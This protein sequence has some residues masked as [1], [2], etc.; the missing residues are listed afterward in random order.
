M[1]AVLGV[2][3]VLLCSACAY[4]PQQIQIAP[5]LGVTAK[6]Y[7]QGMPVTVVARD[8]RSAQV[9]GSRG[10]VYA[11]TSTISISNNLTQ[12]VEQSATARLAAQGFSVNGTEQGTLMTL[13]V[14][15]IAYDV[16][17]NTIPKEIKMEVVMRVELENDGRTLTNRYK[18]EAEHR[19]LASPNAEKNQKM[20]NDLLSQT[21]TRVF[22]DPKVMAFL[23]GQI[24]Q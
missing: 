4:S 11:Q 16:I 6:R 5:D 1:K 2:F 18:T 21:M 12:A 22:E 9:I 20:V 19:L 17:D 24:V 14:D 3:L 10:G 8:E 7:G 23:S 15:E 13:F